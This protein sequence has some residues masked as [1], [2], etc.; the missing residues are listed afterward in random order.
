MSKPVV[1]SYTALTGFETCPLRFYLTRVS[2]EVVEPQGEALVWGNTVHKALE[3]R[4][5]HGAQLP[6]TLE[7]YEPLVKKIEDKPGQLLVEEAIAL[8]RN[9]QPVG[10]WDKTAWVRGKLDVG[11]L[12]STKAAVFDWKTGTRKPDND[13]LTLFAGLVFAVHPVVEQ[14]TTGFIWL[15]DNKFDTKMFTRE[16]VPEIWAEFLPRMQRLERAHETGKWPA[17]PSGLCRQWCPVGRAR[18]EHCGKA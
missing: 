16:Q 8:D 11:K 2:K 3:N 1:H 9:F 10:W 12:G 14:V 4:L 15:K 6:K 7:G 5:R 17:K 18:C 13:Q